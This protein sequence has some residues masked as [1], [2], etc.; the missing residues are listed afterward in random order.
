MGAGPLDFVRDSFMF[1]HAWLTEER[2]DAAE[3][4]LLA[5]MT[6]KVDW[7]DQYERKGFVRLMEYFSGR[8]SISED[9][10]WPEVVRLD[11]NWPHPSYW[12]SF[13]VLLMFLLSC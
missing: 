4:E 13:C 2:I 9:M 7:E 3:A 5:D 12:F 1:I 6:R 8:S 11:W 10:S